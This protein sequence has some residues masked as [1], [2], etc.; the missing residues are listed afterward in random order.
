MTTAALNTKATETGNKIPD[1]TNFATKAAEDERKIRDI[2][3][4]A[5]WV[6]LNTNVPE[7]E[8]K[9]PYNTRFTREPEFDRLTKISFDAK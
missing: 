9:V 1:N 7:I 8:N 2:T 6:S 5:A 3:T 4:L